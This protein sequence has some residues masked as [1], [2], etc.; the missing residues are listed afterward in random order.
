MVGDEGRKV[1]KGRLRLCRPFKDLNFHLEIMLIKDNKK[2]KG[3][4]A[5]GT[6][7]VSKIC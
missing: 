1:V 7:C 6:C 5:L 3:K 2:K 4:L